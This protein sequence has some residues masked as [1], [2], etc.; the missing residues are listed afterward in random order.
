M[1][2]FPIRTMKTHEIEHIDPLLLLWTGIHGAN[3][4]TVGRRDKKLTLSCG[5]YMK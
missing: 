4:N 1:I 5:E 2:L 3:P